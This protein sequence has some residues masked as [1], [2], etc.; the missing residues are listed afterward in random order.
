MKRETQ[1][2]RL[3]EMVQDQM[4]YPAYQLAFPLVKVHRS[5]LKK[6]S[7]DD[8]FLTG[9]ETLEFVLIE[10]K[11]VCARTVFADSGSTPKIEIVD[12]SEDAIEDLGNK[13]Y[14]ILQFS[15]GTVKSKVLAL[16]HTI[17]I[18]HIDLQQVSINSEGKTIAQGILVNVD[19]EIAI[20]IKKVIR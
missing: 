20:Q 19:E 13:K 11:R 7:I 14:S 5:K 6:L 9:F 15:F 12:L 17:D 16:K 1:A 2:Q 3:A 4:H 10:G 18:A 8:L